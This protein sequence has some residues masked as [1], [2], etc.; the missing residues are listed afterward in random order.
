LYFCPFSFGHC[1]VWSSSIFGILITPWVSSISFYNRRNWGETIFIWKHPM[2]D[3][4]H[5]RNIIFIGDVHLCLVLWHTVYLF[6]SSQTISWRSFLTCIFQVIRIPKIEEDQTPQWP[7]E[8]GQKYKQRYIKNIIQK[9][10][11]RATRTPL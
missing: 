5:H 3:D 2:G 9:T 8:K 4:F 1:G 10:K 11:D 6:A 7:K